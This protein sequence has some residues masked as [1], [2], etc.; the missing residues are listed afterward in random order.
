MEY[1]ENST[2]EFPRFNQNDSDSE[3]RI[4]Q[5]QVDDTPPDKESDSQ[6][7]DKTK[8]NR[9]WPELKF[10]FAVISVFL[11]TV[12]V[13]DGKDFKLS[14]Y[15]VDWKKELLIL[16]VIGIIFRAIWKC[17]QVYGWVLVKVYGIDKAKKKI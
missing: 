7:D 5:S 9:W 4:I 10:A 1:F 16:L 2:N 8:K 3:F 6:Y 17:D 13:R 12:L 15:L 11:L 14:S